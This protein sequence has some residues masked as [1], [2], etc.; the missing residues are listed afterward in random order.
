MTV[1]GSSRGHH[2][3]SSPMTARH[4]PRRRRGAP[5]D[6]LLFPPAHL[7]PR[8]AVSPRLEAARVFAGGAEGRRAGAELRVRQRG[9]VV[10]GDVEADEGEVVVE[11]VRVAHADVAPVLVDAGLVAGA[12]VV[13]L[14]VQVLQL[15]GVDG[16]VAGPLVEEG[17]AGQGVQ[18]GLIL[19]APR[20]LRVAEAI[21]PLHGLCQGQL[22]SFALVRALRVWW[23][24]GCAADGAGG[25]DVARAAAGWKCHCNADHMYAKRWNAGKGMNWMD[26]AMP[27]LVFA[28][29]SLRVL[30]AS[31][32]ASFTGLL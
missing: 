1:S 3:S 22:H 31:I 21:P 28:R 9:V 7:L 18:L 13:H 32:V 27:D 19:G 24:G 16:R 4:S 20:E 15:G 2:I 17:V 5:S 10:G 29:R 25:N 30:L 23:G 12:R 14:G 11:D 26:N 8:H 6:A